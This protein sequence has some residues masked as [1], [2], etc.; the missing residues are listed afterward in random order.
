[1]TKTPDAQAP[2]PDEAATS[3]NTA[4]GAAESTAAQSA[5]GAAAGSAA[6]APDKP[7]AT[8]R[9]AVTAGTA[10]AIDR[11]RRPLASRADSTAG[12]GA[13]ASAGSASSGGLLHSADRRGILMGLL[14][15]GAAVVVGS[16]IGNRG[17]GGATQDIE[18]TGNTVNATIKVEGL[19][20]VPDT[21]DVA[22]GDRLVITLDNTADQVHDLVLATGQTTGRV[23]ARAKGTL[24]AG[25]VAG[26]VEGWCSIAGHRAQGMVFHVTAGGAA[27]GAH[28]HGGGQSAQTGSGKDAVPDYSAH[29]P[30]DFKAFDAALPPA[31]SSPDGGPMTHRHTFTVKEQVMQVGGGVTQRRM[32]F[33]GQVPGPVLRGKVGDTFEITLVNDGT[34]S[35]SLDFHAGITPPDK[36]MR[37]INPGESLVYTFKAQHSGIWL[38]HCSTSPMSLHLAAGMHGA[39]IIDPPGLPAVD[40]EYAIV[41]SEVY[42]GPEGGEP[43]TDKI[44]AKTPDLMTF[45]GVAFQY[46]QQPLKAKV[47]ERVRFWVMAAGPSLPT[48]FHAVGLHFDQVF[49]EGAWTLGGPNRIGAAWSG[50]SQALG[51]QPAQGG[52]VECVASEPGHYVFVSHSFADMEKG[53]HGVLEVTA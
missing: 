52:F 24:D 2:S 40:R 5:G 46:H 18:A 32:T 19:R 15:A 13:T 6:T 25:V 29:L 10:P 1:M 8:H 30:A 44:A 27:A 11:N 34:M 14:T 51:L 50:G 38:Y 26:P 47:G 37:S 39:V 49:F 9:R 53:A 31:P 33:N 45:N 22:P 35:H 17:Q 20:F 43:N 16:V 42:L 36:A 12:A 48:S 7:E 21:V 28:Q 23:A 41:A 3:E 4:S